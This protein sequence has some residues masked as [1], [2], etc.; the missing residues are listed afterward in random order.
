MKQSINTSLRLLRSALVPD[1]PALATPLDFSRLLLQP[2]ELALRPRTPFSPA[3]APPTTC[4]HRPARPGALS[5]ALFGCCVRPLLRSPRPSSPNS[6]GSTFT[7]PGA[8]LKTHIARPGSSLLP[9]K[10][11]ARTPLLQTPVLLLGPCSLRL[12]FRSNPGRCS[13]TSRSS[14]GS[15]LDS[16]RLL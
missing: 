16:S 4:R 1:L 15:S 14:P 6:L 11:P 13:L 12:R 3:P 5:G 10:Q 7:A 9:S 2:P 8:H